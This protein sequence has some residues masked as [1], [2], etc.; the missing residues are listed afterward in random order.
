MLDQQILRD[1]FRVLALA[2]LKSAMRDLRRDRV[3]GLKLRQPTPRSAAQVLV[4][5]CERGPVLPLRHQ[6]RDLGRKHPRP[7]RSGRRHAVSLL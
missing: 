3:G 7:R 4:A 2:R 1:S 6:A 5:T